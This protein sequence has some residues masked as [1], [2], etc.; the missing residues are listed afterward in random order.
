[1]VTSFLLFVETGRDHNIERDQSE[2]EGGQRGAHRTHRKNNCDLDKV[3]GFCSLSLPFP[4]EAHS[5]LLRS[6]LSQIDSPS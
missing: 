2:E 3:I 5:H 1:M 6:V 4:F